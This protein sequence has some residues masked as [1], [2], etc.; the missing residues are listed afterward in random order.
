MGIVVTQEG[1]LLLWQYMLGF[2]AAPGYPLLCLLGTN[3]TVVHTDTIATLTAQEFAATGYS[4]ITMTVPGSVASVAKITNGAQV[5]YNLFTF[6]FTGS[7]TIY[8]YFVLDPTL[9]YSLYGEN[10]ASSF[11]YAAGTNVFNL[12]LP[13]T[14]TSPP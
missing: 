5:T 6:N 8:G 10:F 11:V 4:R 2:Y 3:H 12:L 9:T 7:G 1:A 13:P 14:L